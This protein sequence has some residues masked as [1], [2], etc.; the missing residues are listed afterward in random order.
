MLVLSRREGEW[1]QIG[2]DIRVAVTRKGR[3]RISLAITAP[4]QTKVLRGELL[5]RR[6]T[7]AHDEVAATK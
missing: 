1:I 4:P 2:D 3:A 6:E 5:E 7:T